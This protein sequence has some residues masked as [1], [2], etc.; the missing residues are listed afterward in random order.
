[1]KYD[2]QRGRKHPDVALA[3]TI[4]E[5]CDTTLIAQP[6]SSW[7]YSVGL[8]WAGLLI[9]RLTKLTLEEYM[10]QNLFEPLSITGITFWPSQRPDLKNKIPGLVVRGPDGKLVPNTT[11]TINTGAKDC[12]GGHGAY[13]QM[14]DYLKILRSLLANDGKLLKPESVDEMFKPQLGEGSRQA[15]SGF[16]QA[17]NSMLIGEFNPDVPVD[18]GLGGVLFLKDDEGRRKKGTM[19]WGGMVN[20]FWMIDREAGLALTF[21]TQVLPPG[22][23]GCKEMTGVFERAVYKMA[24]IS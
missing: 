7:M 12:F 11:P 1:M 16:V 24:G 6:G 4:L 5:R 20:P 2:L 8:D 17:F 23:A 18:H 22:D 9:Q 21:G 19:S 14:S 15:L 3:P 13:A 10:I